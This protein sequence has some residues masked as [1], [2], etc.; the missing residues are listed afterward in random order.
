MLSI[1]LSFLSVLLYLEGG[2][3]V[4]SIVLLGPPLFCFF[5]FFSTDHV[6]NNKMVFPMKCSA[7]AQG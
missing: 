4:H 7:A 2:Q 5:L 6:S 3:C 1:N